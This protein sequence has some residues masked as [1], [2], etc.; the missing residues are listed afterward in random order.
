MSQLIAVRTGGIKLD[1]KTGQELIE[2]TDAD[3]ALIKTLQSLTDAINALRVDMRG[4]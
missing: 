4:K 3:Y 2:L 1:E